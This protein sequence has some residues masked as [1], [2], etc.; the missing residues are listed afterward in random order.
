MDFR[1]DAIDA[2]IPVAQLPTPMVPEE[3]LLIERRQDDFAIQRWQLASQIKDS[4]LTIKQKIEKYFRSN[5]G[6]RI[7]IE[8]LRYVSDNKSEWAYRVRELSKNY[9]IRSKFQGAPNMPAGIFVLES[10]K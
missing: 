6:Q 10:D 7:T 9:E 1:A 5:V 3:Y 8:E 2:G 4:S